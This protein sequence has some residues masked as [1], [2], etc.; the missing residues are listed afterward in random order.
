MSEPFARPRGCWS[1]FERNN[2]AAELIAPQAETTISRRQF[3]AAAVVTDDN[4]RDA[5]ARGVGCQFFDIGVGHQGNIFMLQRR[6]DGADLRVGLGVDQA[7]KAV[8]G[9][10]ANAFA[11]ARVLFIQH[12][13]Q[14]RVKRMQPEP[15]KV[16]GQ[17]L[18]A[19]LV[20]DG[21]V[22]IGAGCVRFRG[23][24]VALA[25]DVIKRLG[26]TVVRLHSRRRRS[27][28]PARCRHDAESRR[29]LPCAGETAPRRRISC[30]RRHSS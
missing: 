13:P 3:F 24:F 15:G 21:R 22:G 25:M 28:R 27:A 10:A 5:P 30:C 23:I 20:A 16:I 17:L 18:D 14:R 8:T 7:G 29:S 6:I 12:H 4:F 1:F 2:S 19:R 26:F 11:G 9:L